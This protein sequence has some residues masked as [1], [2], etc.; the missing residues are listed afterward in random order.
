MKI[1]LCTVADFA[2]STQDGKLNVMGV[3]DTINAAQFP[4]KHASM[5]LVIRTLQDYRD[6][7]TEHEMKV[8]L[9]GPD[10]EKILEMG[11]KI[12]VPTMEPGQFATTNQIL[13][14]QGV[15][16]PKSG[17]YTFRISMDGSKKEEIHLRVRKV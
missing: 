2:S 14:L 10:G 9:R 16:F 17:D 1:I 15:P 5:A 13:N 11:A 6:S 3:F 8:E 12:R 4:A 7:E